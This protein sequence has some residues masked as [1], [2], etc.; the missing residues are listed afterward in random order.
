MADTEKQTP[1]HTGMGHLVKF[2]KFRDK[3]CTDKGTPRLGTAWMIP[4]LGVG[5]ADP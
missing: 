5:V 3:G 2:V 4:H 1:P